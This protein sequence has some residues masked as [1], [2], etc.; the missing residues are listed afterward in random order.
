MRILVIRGKNLASL[1]GYFEVALNKAPLEAAGLFAITGHTG[2]GKSTLL[3]AMCLA[4]FDKIPRLIG[5]ANVKVGRV[6]ED[7]KQRISSSDVGSIISRGTAGAYAEV[8]FIGI[9]KKTYQAHWEIKRARNKVS[10][11]LQKQSVLLKNLETDEII[12]QNKSDTLE[13]ISEK[14]G[15]TFEQFRRS[16]L[17]AQGDFAAFLKAKS[18]ERSSLLERIT[19]TEI[20]SKLSIS[21]YR[22]FQEQVHKLNHIQEKIKYDMPLENQDRQDLIIK[23]TELDDELTVFKKNIEDRRLMLQWYDVKEQMQNEKMQVVQVL[24]N[25]NNQKNESEALKNE[26]TKTLLVQ[27]VRPLLSNRDGLLYRRSELE[28]QIKCVIEGVEQASVE[29]ATSLFNVKETQNQL[30]Q[31]E[32][33]FEKIKPELLKARELDT[34]IKIVVQECFDYEV[35]TG[36][37]KASLT[38]VENNKVDL[39]VVVQEQNALEQEI[40]SVSNLLVE[41][42]KKRQIISLETLNKNNDNFEQKRFVLQAF[43]QIYQSYAEKKVS[44]EN[45][46]NCYQGF[47]S[48]LLDLMKNETLEQSKCQ[49]SKALL[50]E[51]RRALLMMQESVAQGVQSLRGL[52]KEDQECSVCGSKVHPWADQS[53]ILNQQYLQQTERVNELEKSVQTVLTDINHLQQKIKQEKSEQALQNEHI[54]KINLDMIH[55]VSQWRESVEKTLAKTEIIRPLQNSLQQAVLE[56]ELEFILL[57]EIEQ[58]DVQLGLNKEKEKE[59]ITIQKEIDKSQLCKDRLQS[60]EKK[61]SG[62]ISEQRLILNTIDNLSKQF[63][64]QQEVLKNRK[65]HQDK[66]MSERQVLFFDE[67]LNYPGEDIDKS[68]LI[69]NADEVE[70][71][72]TQRISHL[73]LRYKSEI[74]LLEKL[75]QNQIKITEQQNY[76][77]EHIAQNKQQ[78]QICDSKLDNELRKHSLE[79][80]ELKLLLQHDD[81][82][83]EQQQNFFDDLSNNLIKSDALLLERSSKLKQHDIQFEVFPELLKTISNED[84]LVQLNEQLK[85]QQ[86]IQNEY[87]EKQLELKQDDV[88][89]QR[90]AR[91]LLELETQQ[92]IWKDWADL[93][94]LIGSASGHKFRIFA[95][96]LTLESL[97][98]HANEHLN[99]FARRYQLQRVP[100]TDLELQIMDRDM[101]D[102]VRSVQSLSGGESFLVSLALALGL[103]SLSSTKTQVE[104]LFIDEGFGT[105]DQETLDI[106][107]ASLD[108]LQGLGRKVGIIS[109][110]PILVERIGT[111]VLVEKMGGG[112]SRVLVEG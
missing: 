75:K 79:L 103:A 112:Q 11:R 7:E 65:S 43:C 41:L 9:D 29:I 99:D 44:L 42:Q 22:I 46:T 80:A 16:V 17:L 76:L 15:L 12:G 68:G 24:S 37:L 23:I 33:L 106:A 54:E 31:S 111:R 102:E 96:S 4:L 48:S 35:A 3:D 50:E 70:N 93:N 82:W 58:L 67:L 74:N 66:L 84:L 101:A 62:I 21:T 51:A 89:K 78:Q 6:D 25:L 105:L 53:A 107:I 71:S 34:Q 39:D 14:I 95:Q 59:A 38:K 32:I 81:E 69:L 86:T 91:S 73:S 57:P 92:E 88:K 63:Q 87:Q 47:Q 52:L 10:G 85:L 64:M 77:Q 83:L 109:H 98:A 40:I 60:K 27:D 28:E 97:L 13:L 30:N 18:D 36:D 2:S 20:Y 55:L 49:K 45:H 110:V 26:L 5:S 1:R 72:L 104:S 90:I 61:L 100:G 56:N 94:E 8:E 19:G 108:T